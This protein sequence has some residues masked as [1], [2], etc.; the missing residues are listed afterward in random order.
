MAGKYRAR[1]RRVFD[2]VQS[3]VEGFMA[4]GPDIYS[5]LGADE[6]FRA[7]HGHEQLTAVTYTLR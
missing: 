4:E 5:R 2:T 7:H 3:A 6:K 1:Q